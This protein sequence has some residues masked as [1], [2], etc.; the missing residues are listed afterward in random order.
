MALLVLG[1]VL[2]LGTH[3]LRV[4]APAWRERLQQ[5]LGANAWRGLYS[6]ASLAGLVCIALGYGIARR[7]PVAVWDALAGSR[8]IAATLTLPAF[9]LLAASQIPGNALRARLHHP[10]L[11]GTMLWA[12]AHLLANGSLADVLLFGGF[13]AWAALAY[14]AAQQRDRAQGTVY[15]PGRTGPTLLAA[16][17]GTAAWLVFALWAHAAWIG[18]R[19]FA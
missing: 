16:A 14:R 4:I 5:R 3:S 11:L 12:L 13:L 2:F 8:H 9:V 17:I 19:P 7:D 1:L 15:A 6:L 18:A 10:M